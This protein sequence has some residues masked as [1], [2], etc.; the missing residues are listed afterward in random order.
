MRMPLRRMKGKLMSPRVPPRHP[1]P[2]AALIRRRTAL[3]GGAALPLGLLI[4]GAKPAAALQSAPPAQLTLPAPTGRYRL[5]TTSLYL[6]DRSRPD[7]WVPGQRAQIMIQLWYPADAVD[8]YPRAPWL[9][10]V[11]ARAYK[12]MM[13]LPSSLN[14][15]VT[16]GHLGAPVRRCADGWPV[17]LYSPS[18]GGERSE[19]TCL[20]EDLASR[21]YV[22]V[23]IDHV[24]DSDVVELP[25]GTVATYAVTPFTNA[26]EIAVTTKEIVSSVADV[27]FILDQLAV[28]NRGGNPDPGHPP[29]PHGL[30]GALDL[31]RVGMFGQSDGGS[32]T[33]QAMNADPRIKVGIDLDGTLWTPQAVAAGPGRPLL[34]FGRQNQD[35]LTVSTWAAFW[36]T[37]RGP[38]L[39]L[40]L[41]GSTHDTFTDFA[42]LVP[43]AAPILGKPH[44]W[45]VQ[46][47]GTI[48]GP[49][50]VAVE[51]AYISAYFDRYLRHQNSPLL[52]GPS[53]LYPEVRFAPQD[54]VAR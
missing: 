23:T 48:N 4:A 47:I 39:Q 52:A 17:V 34:L 22:V 32:T 21:G 33:A 49:R 30:C 41:I 7:P 19:T 50:A 27:H 40:N 28:L 9:P 2:R 3:L 54:W 51:R 6:V 24:H 31:D 46:G 10:P 8:G 38:G 13:G 45:V 18:L 16:V 5:G 1:D 12:K 11:T 53:P 35:S 43:Q 15:P 29:L 14:L 42:A 26:N 37:H 36:K 20:V 44:S 25:D